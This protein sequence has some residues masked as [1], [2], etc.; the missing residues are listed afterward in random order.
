MVKIVLILFGFLFNRFWQQQFEI[1]NHFKKNAFFV[2]VPSTA[3]K[4]SSGKLFLL[5]YKKL[6]SF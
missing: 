5:V 6:L 4:K 3:W 1:N 2:A